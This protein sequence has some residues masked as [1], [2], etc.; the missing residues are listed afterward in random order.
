MGLSGLGC[1][2][3]LVLAPAGWSQPATSVKP[4]APGLPAKFDLNDVGAVT[5]IKK[6][7]GG[8]CWTHGTM[9]A[10]EATC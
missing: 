6:Q 3:A 4:A 9:A 2:L 8:T 5:P 10:V 1:V 7:Q